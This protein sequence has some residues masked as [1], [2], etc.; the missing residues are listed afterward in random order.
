MSDSVYVCFLPDET[1]VNVCFRARKPKFFCFD[2]NF[3]QFVN[4]EIRQ[5][6]GNFKIYV[7]QF[8]NSRSERSEWAAQ[9]GSWHALCVWEDIFGVR[10]S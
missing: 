1:S 4:F 10:K 8:C 6:L 2:Q 7:S 3:S 5:I 9:P